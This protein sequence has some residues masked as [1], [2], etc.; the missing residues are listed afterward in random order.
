MKDRTGMFII[1]GCAADA[2]SYEASRYGQGLLTYTILQAMKGVALREDKFV[3]VNT[4]LNYSRE[5]VPKLAAG[6]GGIQ[7]PQLLIPKGGSLILGL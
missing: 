5:E 6:V 3:D 4:L 7:E 1:S 2:V